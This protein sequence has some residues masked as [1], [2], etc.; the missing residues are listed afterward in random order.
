[1]EAFQFWLCGI[2]IRR[3]LLSVW[4]PSEAEFLA[5]K[6]EAAKTGREQAEAW[7]KEWDNQHGR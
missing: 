4:R 5:L 7:L 6:E 1:L 2:M 3:P